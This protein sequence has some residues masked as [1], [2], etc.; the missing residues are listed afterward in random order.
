MSQH[1]NG[2]HAKK[3]DVILGGMETIGS[4]ERSCDKEEMKHMFSNISEGG[5]ASLLYDLFGKKRVDDEM[6]EFLQ[7]DFVPRY[8]GGIGVTRLINA[9][10]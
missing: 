6:E 7:H 1:E 10:S 8:G 5:Y 9:M 3:C 4:A 2:T